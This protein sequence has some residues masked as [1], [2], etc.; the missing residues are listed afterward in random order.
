MVNGNIFS[1][2]R[3]NQELEREKRLAKKRSFIDPAIEQVQGKRGISVI[4]AINLA[5]PTNVRSAIA[6][7]T[8]IKNQVAQTNISPQQKNLDDLKRTFPPSTVEK[9]VKL[10]QVFGGLSTDPRFETVTLVST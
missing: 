9:P 4:Q 2:I 1:A 5:R 10:P 7:P 6:K 8:S 3:R